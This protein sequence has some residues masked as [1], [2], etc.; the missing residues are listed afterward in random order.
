MTFIE[1]RVKAPPFA[2]TIE[3]VKMLRHHIIDLLIT[4]IRAHSA[5]IFKRCADD[6]AGRFI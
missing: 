4:E 2:A 3:N 6:A 5:S 1:A